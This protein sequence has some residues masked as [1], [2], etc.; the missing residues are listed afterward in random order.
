MENLTVE[1]TK[2]TPSIFLDAQRGTLELKG[3]SYPENAAK[4]YT[5][6]LEK[7]R[8]FLDSINPPHLEVTLEIIYLNS[9][10]S[11]AILNLLDMLDGFA[12]SGR[13]VVI[14]W[15]YHEEDETALECGEEFKEDLEFAV[16][17]LTPITEG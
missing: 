11:K 6:V 7:I 14:N 5:P 15:R 17:N 16:F 1:P 3:K 2:S 12:R 9:S 8:S 13:E 10:S 4:F